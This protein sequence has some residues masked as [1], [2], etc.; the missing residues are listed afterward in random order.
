M[1]IGTIFCWEKNF[2]YNYQEER[3]SVGIIGEGF[4]KQVYNKLCINNIK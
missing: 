1:R 4:Q 2:L 3:G